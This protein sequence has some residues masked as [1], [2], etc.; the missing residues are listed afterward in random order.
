MFVLAALH[1]AAAN[2]LDDMVAEL[3]RAGA[4]VNLT[5]ESGNTPLHWA[6]LNSKDTIVR[7]L[8][9]AGADPSK[10]NQ[11]DRTP[12]D[13]A[14]SAGAQKVS[15]QT[16]CGG[17]HPFSTSTGAHTTNVTRPSTYETAHTRPQ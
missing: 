7:A 2:G 15:F 5:N 3:L 14:L 12:V 13:E 6:C 4:D 1:M 10:C 9:V 16:L 8:M 17:S 11:F